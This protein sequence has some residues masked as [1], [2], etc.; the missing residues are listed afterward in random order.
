MRSV[1]AANEAPR[2]LRLLRTY[3]GH[4][5]VFFGLDSVSDLLYIKQIPRRR[6][7]N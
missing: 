7:G 2:L 3:Y 6:S 1:G 4:V 5:F